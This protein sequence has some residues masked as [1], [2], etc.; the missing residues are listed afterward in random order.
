[1]TD[2]LPIG[3]WIRQADELLT[4][5]I[6]ESQAACNLSRT[7]WQLLNALHENSGMNTPG[8]EDVMRPFAGSTAIE[9]A[10]SRFQKDALVFITQQNTFT[11]TDAGQ[12]LHTKAFEQQQLFRQNAM[13]GISDNDYLITVHTLQKIAGNINTR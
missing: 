6:N 7:E 13:A 8:L 10:L 3:Y 4:K 1:M 12:A 5:G 11:L 9:R 2:N